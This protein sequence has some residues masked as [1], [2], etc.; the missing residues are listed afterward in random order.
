[1]VAT[2]YTTKWEIDGETIQWR[3]NEHCMVLMGY[4]KTK[5][6]VIMADPLRGIVEY[7]AEKFYTP[8][9]SYPV[10]CFLSFLSKQSSHSA[11][12]PELRHKMATMS[13]NIRLSCLLPP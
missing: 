8:Y 2:K 7:S 5:G 13:D 6:T 10:P 3:G 12:F 9:V 11:L 4:N 1:M